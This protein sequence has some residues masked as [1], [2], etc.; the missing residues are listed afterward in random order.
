MVFFLPPFFSFLSRIDQLIIFLTA[1]DFA[2]ISYSR[3]NGVDMKA[4]TATF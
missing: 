2:W 3:Q 1:Q 4:W